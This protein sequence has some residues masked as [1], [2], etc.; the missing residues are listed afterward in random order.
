MYCNT[1]TNMGGDAVRSMVKVRSKVAKLEL[2]RQR[3]Q[4][5]LLCHTGVRAQDMK[6]IPDDK[7]VP[8][9]S[10]E[11]VNVNE[12]LKFPNQG[13]VNKTMES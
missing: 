9:F 10:Y 11:P 3:R 8:I 13:A 2:G 4:P 6:N 5:Y 12:Y 7:K 1:T